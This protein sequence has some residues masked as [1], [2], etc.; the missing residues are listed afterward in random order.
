MTQKQYRVTLVSLKSIPKNL[1]KQPFST[2]EAVKSGLSKATLSRMVKSGVLDRIS[3]GVYQVSEQSVYDQESLYQ[4][5]TIRSGL[6][7]AICL[8]SALEH[9][10][11]TDEVSRHTW[12]LVPASKRI[13]APS[14]KLVRSRNPHWEIG[15]KKKNGYWITSIERTLVDCILSM[16]KIGSQIALSALKRALSEKKVKLGRVMDIAKQM[17]VEKRILP[18]IQAFSS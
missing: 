14:I 8:L 4:V 9:Y 10:N 13:T 2:Q 1:L 12:I 3:L 7:S 6:P 5:A 16:K 11:L 15:I 18:Y 17:G